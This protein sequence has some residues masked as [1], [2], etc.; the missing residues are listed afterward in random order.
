MDHTLEYLRE[1]L[2]NW[3]DENETAFRIYKKLENHAYTNE[4]DFVNDLEQDEIKYL[5]EL[6]HEEM[7]YADQEQDAVRLSQLNEVFEQLY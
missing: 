4:K 2:S 3:I 6:V 1:S 7:H 5:S